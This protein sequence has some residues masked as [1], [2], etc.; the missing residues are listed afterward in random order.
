MKDDGTM[1]FQ[2]EVESTTQHGGLLRSAGLPPLE[3]A[4]PPN[5]HGPGGV[6]T[7]E[8]LFVASVNAC[9]MTTF[10]AIAE[11][12]KL[13]VAS[14][15]SSAEGKL[16]RLEQLGYQMTG[17]VLR[18][19]L[20]IKD[21]KDLDRAAR[22]LD[23]AKRRCLISKSVKSVVTMEPEIFHEQKP[24]YPCPPVAESGV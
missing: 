8:H 4:A 16:E 19:K 7:P 22:V 12:S 15:T 10:L 3:V 2:V 23:K 14:F 18:P 6:W 11:N 5:F 21:S 9:F 13:E 17:I 1:V 20:M 24:A